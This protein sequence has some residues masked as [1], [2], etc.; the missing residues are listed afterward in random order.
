MVI[1]SGSRAFTRQVFVR[2]SPALMGLMN[3]WLTGLTG[4]VPDVGSVGVL[5]RTSRIGV[6]GLLQIRFVTPTN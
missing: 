2:H 4:E 6:Q 3:P 5:P 1:H